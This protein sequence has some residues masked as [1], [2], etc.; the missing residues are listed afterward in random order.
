M[1]NVY[2]EPSR[3]RSAWGDWKFSPHPH[4]NVH[5]IQTP[6]GLE[7]VWVPGQIWTPRM[8]GII[9]YLIIINVL[10]NIGQAITVL[11]RI[12]EVP[13]SYLCLDTDCPELFVVPLNPSMQMP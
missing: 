8:R 3:V 12:L 11:T 6:T 1:L 4:V 7:A 5:S 13:S 2:T 10:T 9:N